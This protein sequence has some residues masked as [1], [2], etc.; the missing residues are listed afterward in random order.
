MLAL[1]K[2]RIAIVTRFFKLILRYVRFQG[3][4]E[5]EV[6][7]FYDLHVAGS[8]SVEQKNGNGST[9]N[10]KTNNNG[11]EVNRNEEQNGSGEVK[12][13]AKKKPNAPGSGPLLQQAYVSIDSPVY[14]PISVDRVIYYPC[15]C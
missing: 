4:C 11:V 15:T 1:E 9:K 5:F 8:A 12:S 6:Y 13:Q 2:I 14:I 10:N 7:R 3:L